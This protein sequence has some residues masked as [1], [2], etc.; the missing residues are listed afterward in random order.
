MAAAIRAL[1]MDAVQQANSGHP[2]MPM[3]MAEIAVALWSGVLSHNPANPRW[4]NRDR[5]V[6]SNGHGSMLIYALL[7]LT[8]YDLPVSELRNFRQLHSRTPGHPE[9]GITPGIETTTGPLGQGL[10]NAVGMAL[11]EKLLAAE[12]NRDGHSIVDHL[13]WVFAGDGCL[14]EGISHEAC[15]LAGTHRLSRLVMLYDDNGISIDGEVR[16]WFSDD[17]A[18]RFRAYGWHVIGGV[19]GHDVAAV[20]AAID[21][22][23]LWAREGRDGVFAPTLIMCRTIIGKGSPGRANSAKAHGEPLGAAEIEATRA[24]IGWNAAPFEIPDEVRVAWDGRAG[25]MAREADWQHRFEAYRRAHPALAAEF[26]R[27]MSGELGDAFDDARSAAIADAIARAET[28]A[29]RKASQNALNHFGPALGELIGGSADLTGSNLTDFRGCG[30]LRVDSPAGTPPGRHIN[31]GVREFGMSAIMNGLA[32]HGGFIPYGGTF[33]TFSDY[34]RNAL[35][36]AALMKQRVIFVFTHDS[37]GLGEDGP[38]HQ[39]VEHA[40]SLR[41]I[42]SMDVWRPADTVESAVAWAE[43]IARADGPSSLLFS[44]QAV[45]FVTRSSAQV[46]AIARG[47]Y[48]LRDAAGAKAVLI[49]TGSELGLVLAARDQLAA[50]GI[51]VRI[52]SMPS[53]TVFDRQ[54]TAYRASV[55]PAG[56][57]RVAVEAGVTDFWWK[58][59]V[60]AVVGIDRFGESAPAGAL[61]KLF[62]FTA[63]NVA[64]TVREVLRRQAAQRR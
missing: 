17:T 37:I 35:R 2:G 34:S 52:V 49:A 19:D 7:H 45:P 62:G 11:A 47:A 33:L 58:Y 61:N 29:T 14:M 50:D 10:A 64:D 30:A 31:Y 39:P 60:D 51:E 22:A 25:G 55:L 6:L 4:A 32:L 18:A 28:I 9:V 21:Q 20:R 40:A 16:H 42:P 38:T 13:T 5:F 15:S 53:T 3:G 23:S 12:F 56:V 36:M 57:P 41:L 43:A 27:R 24:A 8:G 44:R 1:A 26:E 46:D 59:G 54:S 63:E 48:V